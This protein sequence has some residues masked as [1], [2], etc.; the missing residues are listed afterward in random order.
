MSRSATAHTIRGRITRMVAPPLAAMLVLL[1]VISAGEI[2]GYRAAATT[3]ERVSVV[4]SLQ[5]LVQQL[6]DER[7]VTTGLLAGDETL[8]GRLSAVRQQVDARHA[9]VR[10]LLAGG[11]ELEEQAEEALGQLD[12][13]AE[14]RGG[15][16]SGDAGRAEVFESYTE[17]IG[18]LGEI[19]LDLE[20]VADDRLRRGAESLEQLNFVKEASAQERAFVT[21]VLSAGGFRA[22][23][24]SQFAGIVARRDLALGEFDEFASP[25]AAAAKTAV[26]GSAA[27]TRVRSLEATVLDS[28]DGRTL[29]L[30]AGAWSSSTATLLGDLAGLGE[31]IGAAVRDRAGELREQAAVRI[32]VLAAIVLACLAGSVY[33]ATSGTRSL[34]GPLAALADEA[35]R[36]AGQRLPEAVRRAAAGE[37]AG[38]PEPVPVAP[39]ATREIGQVAEAF[40][41]V[42]QTAYT[43]ATEQAQ[44][45]RTSA[46]SLANLGRRNQ[47]LLRRQLGFITRLE[48]EEASPAGLANLFELDHLATRMRRNAESLLVL[49]GAASP[50]QWAGPV[51]LT[52]VVRAAVSEVEEYRRVTL[53]KM[54][55]ALVQGSMAGSLAHML[56]ELVENGLSFSPPD[57]EVEVHGRR[58]GDGYL[59]AVCDQGVGMTAEEIDR[60]NRRLR[61]EGEGEF[62]VAPARFLGH[63]VV[64]R[65]AREL[66]VDVQLTPSAV[67]GLTARISIPAALL[68]EEPQPREEERVRPKVD[69]VDYV[70]LEDTATLFLELDDAARTPNGLRKRTPRKHRA[71]PPAPAAA[72]QPS[73]AVAGSPDAVGARLTALRDGIQRGSHRTIQEETR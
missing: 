44:L 14:L 2:S 59:V 9:Q 7:G 66:G 46:E 3:D 22:G 63:H 10:D 67:T 71:R 50:R 27:A 49:V 11:D 15:A 73:V 57:L 33:L 26:L 60:A 61:G 32:S 28:G 37:R 47:N 68:T 24:Y 54:D 29:R 13:L 52:D 38:P 56:A 55:D 43:L 42:Q 69:E 51:P 18:E 35:N 40:G 1:S 25:E 48:Q 45:R 64:G 8:R 34:A 19:F 41:R 6:Q 39:G 17:T 72:P 23:E 53:R 12:G 21:G 31:Q 65:L 16:D 5:S 20:T 30:D 70:V 4:L 36:L 58:I 62:V